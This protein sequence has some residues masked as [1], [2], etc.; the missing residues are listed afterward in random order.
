MIDAAYE[1]LLDRRPALQEKKEE[2]YERARKDASECG[3]CGKPFSVQTPIWLQPV[4]VH[5]RYN[6]SWRLVPVCTQCR[7]E[8]SAFEW[9]KHRCENC[10]RCV[11]RRRIGWG[12]KY[13]Y[14]SHV[15]CSQRCRIALHNA[16]A[17]ANRPDRNKTCT[18]CNKPFLAPR[19][20]A[21]TC[22]SAC[23]QK[24]YRQRY[25]LANGKA[26]P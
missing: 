25:R 7:G 4:C 23:R 1:A 9:R 18:V 12:S 22:S 5:V 11:Y 6:R 16:I 24:A 17:K 3:Q 21:L 13:L 26:A 15:T 2:R 19:A 14:S 8:R 10:G 20:D